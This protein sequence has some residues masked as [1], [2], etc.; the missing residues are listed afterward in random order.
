MATPGSISGTNA[1]T[2]ANGMVLTEAFDRIGKR[3]TELDRHQI[4][5]GRISMNLLTVE[6]GNNGVNLWK[7]VSGTIDVLAEQFTYSLPS[8]LIDLTEVWF[9]T[10]DLTGSG[11][12]SDRFM[13]PMDRGDYAMISNKY[14]PGPPNRFWYQ[15]LRAAP[16]ITVWPVPPAGAPAYVINWFGLSQIDDIGVG[17]GEIPE[18]PYRGL[19]A[20]CAGLS[21]RLAEKFAPERLQ[22][23]QQEAERAW[24]LFH[25]NDQ[26]SGMVTIRPN[27]SGY[28]RM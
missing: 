5:S 4:I 8:N 23:K 3:P 21:V 28:R 18:A 24:N 27:L 13:T 26:E 10:V 14:A 20:L 16:L 17:G 12:N 15:R 9:T 1:F 11:Q 6:W 22:E 25:S 7:V 19:D 2:L